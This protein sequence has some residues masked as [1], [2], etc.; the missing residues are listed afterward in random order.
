MNQKK[1]LALYGSPRKKGNSISLS[2]ELLRGYES[3]GG[4]YSELFLSKMNI[5]PCNAC[6]SCQRNSEFACIL[7]DDMQDIYA[8]VKDSE[9][10]LLA[11]PIYSFSFSAQLKLFIDR[12]Y[13]FWKPSDNLLKNKK[14]IIVLT[15]ADDDLFAS[16]GVNA[17]RTLKDW[18]SFLGSDV[19]GFIHGSADKAGEILQNEELMKKAFK[20]GEQLL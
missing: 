14:I 11:S 12:C 4:V 5:S 17:I 9:I 2:K 15:Y 19:I 6:D 3:K 1:I 10:I 20:M 8:A 13:A 7:Q 18:F 16:G